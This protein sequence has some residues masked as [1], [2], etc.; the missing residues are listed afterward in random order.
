MPREQRDFVGRWHAASSSDEYIRAAREIV[1]QLQQTAARGVAG[2]ADL[3]RAGIDDLLDF[4]QS[5]GYT[6]DM[7]QAQDKKLVLLL[8]EAA[9]VDWGKPWSRR[10]TVACRA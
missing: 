10:S 7:M 9:D 4:L 8:A 6:A 5:Q 2:N 3:C 1:L